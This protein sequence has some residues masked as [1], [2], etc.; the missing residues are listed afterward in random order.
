M[1]L[2][3]GDVSI[4]RPDDNI[5]KSEAIKLIFKARNIEKKYSTDNW[6]ADYAKTA[7]EL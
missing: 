5:T 7:S 4:F 3:I 2:L 6:Q 1:Y